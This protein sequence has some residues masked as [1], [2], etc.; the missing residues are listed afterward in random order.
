[1]VELAR[2]STR[3]RPETVALMGAAVHS[4]NVLGNP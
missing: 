1:M 2:L 3:A 4:T